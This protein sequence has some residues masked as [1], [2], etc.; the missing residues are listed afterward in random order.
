MHGR[1]CEEE[2]RVKMER[3][4]V[5]PVRCIRY[6]R[7]PGFRWLV[8]LTFFCGSSLFLA[9]NPVAQRNNQISGR[10]VDTRTREPLVTVNVYL[11]DTYLGAITDGNGN[12]TITRIPAGD[13]MLVVDMIGYQNVTK[14]PL[15]LTSGDAVQINFAL[16]EKQIVFNRPVTVTATRGKSIATEIPSSVDVITL[17]TL[18][19]RN[20]DNIAEA[21]ENVQ[22]VYIK[23]YGGLGDLK[24]IS[25][26]GS[27]SAQVL[28]L[29]D[30]QRINSAQN[31]QVDLSTISVEGVERI[32]VVRG[33]NSAIYGADA[34]GG[35]VNIITKRHGE[36]QGFS[37]SVSSM[38]GSF[39]SRSYESSLLYAKGGQSASLSSKWMSAD[40]D[41]SYT[42]LYGGRE[43][44]LNSDFTSTDLFAKYRME[45]GDPF[46]QKNMEISWKYFTSERGSPGGI[47]VPYFEARSENTNQQFNYL[48]TGKVF[49]LLNDI[50]VQGY[51]HTG[52]STYDNDEGL[53]AVHSFFNNR[54]YGTEVQMHSVLTE[55]QVFT[56]GVGTRYDWLEAGSF[57]NFKKRLSY[58]FFALSETSIMFSQKRFLKSVYIVPSL[59][60]DGTDDF[61]DTFSP[62]VGAVVNFDL[63]HQWLS[64]FKFNIGASYRAPTFNDLYWPEDAWTKGNP[65]LRPESGGDWDV[66]IRLQYPILGG[67]Y[68]EST[69]FSNEMDNLIVWQESAG[70]WSPQNVD[71]SRTQGVETTLSLNPIPRIV[72]ASINHTYLH[73]TNL[74]DERTVKGKYLVYRPRHTVN[75]SVDITY[76]MATLTYQFNYTTRRYVKPSNTIWLDP[77]EVSDVVLSIRQRIHNLRPKV[78]LQVKNMFDEEYQLIRHHPVPGREYRLTLGIDFK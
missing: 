49:N 21:L 23:D 10:V 16:E 12:Y 41:F 30:G 51:L 15:H 11:K 73:A 29:L 75:A 60:Y 33:S 1:F 69:Y 34:V 14:G 17:E 7:I 3:K 52:V 76:G 48:F 18:E 67:L 35:V 71:R 24:T 32:E 55:W 8:R 45:F 72:T 39:G 44:R 27:T 42:D 31:G 25:L 20:P 22:G 40:G 74:S 61:G 6:Y 65:D 78:S 70:L 5:F 46:Y 13:Y 36:S 43:K 66:G 63:G 47:D 38:V 62:K 77:Y 57:P 19:L 9:G 50:R 64:T 4:V 53:V 68:F 56:Y 58:N 59:R 28:I 2:L 37:G 54:A 26:R